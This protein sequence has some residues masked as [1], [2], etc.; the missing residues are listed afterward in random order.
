[1]NIKVGDRVKLIKV[2][3]PP[4]PQYVSLIGEEGVVTSVVESN[5]NSIGVKLDIHNAIISFNLKEVIA[6]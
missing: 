3:N 6:I 1:M 4:L 5:L 2:H